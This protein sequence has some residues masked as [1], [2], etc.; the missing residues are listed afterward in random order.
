MRS[1]VSRRLGFLGV[2]ALVWLLG[3]AIGQSVGA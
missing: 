3:G 2:E 1:V